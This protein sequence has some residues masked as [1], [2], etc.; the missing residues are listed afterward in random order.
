MDT[1]RAF[2][3]SAV[4]RAV[5]RLEHRLGVRVFD[6][7][8]RAVRL[9]EEGRR[10]YTEIA[11]LL[12]RLEEAATRGAGG[13]AAVR[14][15]LRVNVD[16][17]IG[18]FVLPAR[19]PEFLAQNPELK[20][21][22]LVRDQLDNSVAGD[23]DV[24]VRFGEP[25][26]SSLTCRRLFDTPVLTC[27]SPEYVARHGRPGHPNELASGQHECVQYLDPAT[28]RP[29]PWE[30]R[31]GEEV[32][33]VDPQGRLVVNDVQAL[34]AACLA[35]HGICQTLELY[36]RP[37]VDDGRLVQLLPEWSGERFPVYVYHRS[38][39][40]PPARVRAFL[41]FVVA[42]TRQSRA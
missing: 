28:G 4:S 34:L 12:A 26:P 13:A 3:P 23:F 14:G 38:K 6:R 41:D 19:L 18:Q 33:P 2:T 8:A 1:T 30:F 32:V 5:S 24:A 40:L 31:R 21:D 35:G 9:T 15:R 7:D 25:R 27:A 10:L 17:A 37:M 11:P 16:A 42:A 39:R 29:F 36:A 20:I 22:F